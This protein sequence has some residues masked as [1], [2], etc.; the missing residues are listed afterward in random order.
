MLHDSY[1]TQAVLGI[2][3]RAERQPDMEYVTGTFVDNGIVAQLVN[4]DNQIVYGRRGTGKTHLLR[5]LGNLLAQD[6]DNAVC[7]L[8][9]RM[10]GSTMQF[11]DDDIPV[12]ARVISFFR[13]V[14]VEVYNTLY[15]HAAARGEGEEALEVLA[16]FGRVA[17]EPVVAYSEATLGS[18][19]ATRRAGGERARATLG[20]PLALFAEGKTERS[21]QEEAETSTVLHAR[22]E[23]KILFPDLAATLRDALAVMGCRLY[24][25]LDEWSSLPSSVQPYLAEFFKRGLLTNPSVTAKIASLEYRS[26]FGVRKADGDLL[27][28]EMGSDIS[29]EL[30][31]DDYYVYDRHPGGV[32]AIFA[33]MLYSHINAELLPGYLLDNYQSTSGLDL[34]LLLFTSEDAFHHL[35]RAS[36]GVARDLIVVFT[37]AYMDARNRSAARIDQAAVAR[38]ARKWYDQDKSQNLDDELKGTLARI[39]DEVVGKRRRFFLLPRDMERNPVI[40]RLFDARVLH[41]VQRGF[42][43]PERPGTRYNVYTLDYGVYADVLDD[44]AA[45]CGCAV[46]AGEMMALLARSPGESGF[47]QDF[48]LPAHVLQ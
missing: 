18:R 11:S 29:A 33:N 19:S 39:I 47:G 46:S 37:M 22:P 2:H 36:E 41:L 6:A 8:D 17:S 32:A 48:T 42:A 25:L 13:D 44:A 38:A 15:D 3:R 24:L 14:L 9:M 35:V 43:Y 12:R 20:F 30:D 4:R 34:H 21:H 40:Q 16:R 7:Y 5:V 1:I 23:D 27:G 31:L 26:R 45:P 10:I 28:F